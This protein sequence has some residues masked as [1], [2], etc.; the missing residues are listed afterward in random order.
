VVCIASLAAF[1]ALSKGYPQHGAGKVPLS[2]RIARAIREDRRANRLYQT[3][4]KCVLPGVFLAL[5]IG[6]ILL[7]LNKAVYVVADSGG[8]FCPEPA[9]Q[10]DPLTKRYPVEKLLAADAEF[11]T[12]DMCTDTGSW[13]Q[14]GVRYEVSIKID[15]QWQ[16][17]DLCADT[18]GVYKHSIK[19][20]LATPLKR[21]WSQP[22]FKPI[23]RIGPYGSHEYVLE[24]VDPIFT[25]TCL[26]GVLNA[27]LTPK[28]SG[29]LYVY[30]NDA[31]LMLPGWTHF[32]YTHN[33][34]RNA[35]SAKLRVRR[36]TVFPEGGP[37]RSQ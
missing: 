34:G 27:E 10:P 35:G 21:W 26:N 6:L 20:N 14:E 11:K 2:L 19:H 23:A 15:S 31:V 22:Y 16:D 17:G 36:V 13:L 30:V 5:S 18:L 37:P 1:G 3:L 8:E 9:N 33:S 28:E 4:R 25:G 7:G 32:F 24:P 12:I 29:E